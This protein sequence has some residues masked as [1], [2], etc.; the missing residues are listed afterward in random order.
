MVNKTLPLT[1][2]ICISAMILIPSVGMFQTYAGSEDQS[3]NKDKNAIATLLA[4]IDNANGVVLLYPPDWSVSYSGL[5][6]PSIVAFYSPVN[7]LSDFTSPAKV[8]LSLT[9]F[10][11]NITLEEYT[12]Q[13]TTRL[14]NMLLQASQNQNQSAPISVRSSNPVTVAGYPG[15]KVVVSL[16][17]GN[18]S[19][20]KVDTMQ[21]WTIVDN[22][23]LYT[24]TY[25]ADSTKFKAYLPDVTH[26]INSL[27]IANSTSSK[28]T[29]D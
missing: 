1:L 15:H 23:K 26:I 21:L 7:N 12:N 24:I 17:P 20:F 6:H 16:Q 28:S 22:N 27:S 18:Q 29:S 2:C 19:Q 13:T 9:R 8:I 4:Y 14:Y 3:K 25:I 10:K 11:Q 5:I